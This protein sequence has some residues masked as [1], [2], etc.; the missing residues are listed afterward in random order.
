MRNSG[1]PVGPH[2]AHPRRIRSAVTVD[3]QHRNLN[4]LGRHSF[5]ASTPVAGTLS[6]L[7]DPDAP[8]PDE[9]EEDEE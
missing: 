8:E 6:P 4:L 5:T 7:R 1:R 9:D 2:L 3:L